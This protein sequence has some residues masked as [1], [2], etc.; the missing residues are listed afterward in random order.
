[1][2]KLF[3]TK[4]LLHRETKIKKKIIGIKKIGINNNIDSF[5]LLYIWVIKMKDNQWQ[6][7]AFFNLH[8]FFLSL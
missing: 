2:W 3:L 8:L 5:V 4:H 1:M 6:E 7:N